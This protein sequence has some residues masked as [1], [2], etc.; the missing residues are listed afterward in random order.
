ML[1]ENVQVFEKNKPITALKIIEEPLHNVIVVVSRNEV[2]VV[3][4]QHCNHQKTCSHCVGLRD[5]HCAWDIDNLK[6]VNKR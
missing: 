3:P 5:P 2:A 6:C 1:V 4:I